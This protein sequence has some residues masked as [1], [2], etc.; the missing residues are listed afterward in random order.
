MK[1]NLRG[2]RAAARVS[3][4]RGQPQIAT[5]IRSHLRPQSDATDWVEAREEVRHVAAPNRPAR[6]HGHGPSVLDAGFLCWQPAFALIARKL[7]SAITARPAAQS[8]K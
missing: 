2:R 5:S 7:G 6:E 4:K 3:R 1:T 8:F